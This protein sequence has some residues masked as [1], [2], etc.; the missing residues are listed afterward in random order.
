MRSPNH[1][2]CISYVN[3]GCVTLSNLTFQRPKYCC[4]SFMLNQRCLMKFAHRLLLD[5]SGR[6]SGNA[7]AWGE[8]NFNSLAADLDVKQRNTLH[9][10]LPAI[11]T[12]SEQNKTKER[13][14]VSMGETRNK[15]K[16][17]QRL[18][19]AK[20]RSHF[21]FSSLDAIKIIKQQ[22]YLGIS[23]ALTPQGSANKD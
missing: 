13:F 7:T 15:R 14:E 4:Q 18:N 21:H 22:L 23:D 6:Y 20:T 3:N 5:K 16:Q 12:N 10:H 8:S 1:A 9:R 17:R 19:L 11:S 2:E